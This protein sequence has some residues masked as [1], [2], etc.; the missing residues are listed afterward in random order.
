M[1]LVV[2]QSQGAAGLPSDLPA[3]YMA[4]VAISKQKEKELEEA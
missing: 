1:D 3:D 4:A 2:N